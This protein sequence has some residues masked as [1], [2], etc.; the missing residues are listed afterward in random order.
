[1]VSNMTQTESTNTN[2]AA[3]TNTTES[4]RRENA[5]FFNTKIGELSCQ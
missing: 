4:T 3:E 2:A 5:G 1:M